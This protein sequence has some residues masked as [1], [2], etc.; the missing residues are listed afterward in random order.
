LQ[1]CSLCCS[2]GKDHSS[3]QAEP[4]EMNLDD[5]LEY[6]ADDELVEVRFHATLLSRL[7]SRMLLAV[8]IAMVRGAC[9]AHVFPVRCILG[10]SL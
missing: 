6:I 10:R 1:T 5:C 8:S 4:I 3:G 7:M 2:A 9:E